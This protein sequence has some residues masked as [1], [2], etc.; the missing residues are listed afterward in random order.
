[1][2]TRSLIGKLNSDKT[3]VDYIYCHWDGYIGHNGKILHEH[4]NTLEKV[5]ALLALGDLSSLGKEIGEKHDFDFHF[6]K[7]G[8]DW[9]TAYGRDRGEDN[10]EMA[11]TTL[12]DYPSENES[13]EYHY[14]FT[15]EGWKVV[16]VC[17]GDDWELVA[18][19]V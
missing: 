12:E 3:T 19:I 18:D 6:C 5:D 4:Y 1:M 11:T 15:N 2:A 7:P 13:T 9:C 8:E 14:L 17:D 16:S 10:S